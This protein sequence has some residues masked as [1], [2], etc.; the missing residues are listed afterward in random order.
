[1]NEEIETYIMLLKHE[2]FAEDIKTID[3]EFIKQIVLRA[4]G[5][6]NEVGDVLNHPAV[7]KADSGEYFV[8]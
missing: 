2:M 3:K 8:D 6:L 4:G 1:M 5:K 7:R